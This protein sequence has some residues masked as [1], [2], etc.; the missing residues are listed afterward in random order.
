MSPVDDDL[1][2]AKAVIGRIAQALGTKSDAELAEKLGIGSKTT[3]SAWRTRNSVPYAECVRV[4]ADCNASLDWLLLG[5]GTMRRDV[6]PG[7][8]PAASRL[9]ED[10]MAQVIAGVLAW[11]ESADVEAEPSIV[12]RLVIGTYRTITDMTPPPTGEADVADK[13]AAVLQNF[14]HLIGKRRG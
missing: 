4:S 7:P 13:V 2:S 1:H 5:M 14:A 10:R 12:G 9:D 8:S 6:E 11:M 3:V